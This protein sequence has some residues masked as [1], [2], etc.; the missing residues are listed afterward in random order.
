M[1]KSGKE[2]ADDE[3]DM[4]HLESW[5]RFLVHFFRGPIYPKNF[6]GKIV[7][8]RDKTLEKLFPKEITKEFPREK[9]CT[10]IRTLVVKQTH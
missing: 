2:V 3:K 10:K 5:S 4:T 7:V 9:T 6:L 8:F 1:W